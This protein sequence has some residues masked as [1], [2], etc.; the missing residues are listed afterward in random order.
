VYQGT[1]RVPLIVRVPRLLPKRVSELVRIVD[2]MPTVLDVLGV[3]Q[4]PTDGTSLVGLMT[5]QIAHLD[6]DAYS[7]SLYPR[8]FGWAELRTIRAGRFKFVSAP[9]PELYDLEKDPTET[10]NLYDE[11]IDLAAAMRA[12]LD[13]VARPS[14]ADMTAASA[15]EPELVERLAA[16]GYVSPTPA[17]HNNSS[18]GTL[19]DPKDCIGIYNRIVQSR[20]ASPATRRASVNR[21]FGLES[22]AFGDHV[23]C[24]AKSPLTQ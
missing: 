15:P 14:R 7:E 20:G 4:R 18:E 22:R 17:L 13:R 19:E 6:L 23:P 3:H 24:F 5:G 9:R 10:R 11:R 21:V 2:V 1:L 8:R 16:L 12:V